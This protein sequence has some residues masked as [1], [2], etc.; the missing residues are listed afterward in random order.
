M[1]LSKLKPSERKIEI[2]NPGT[3]EPIGLRVD[4]VH[5]DDERLKKLK[6]SIQDSRVRL[7]SKG[8]FFKAEDIENNTDEL[9][10]TAMTAWEWYNPTGVQGD[11]GFDA[12][13]QPKWNGEVNPAFSRKT[14]MEMFTALPWFRDQLLKEMGDEEAFFSN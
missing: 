9:V 13:K 5:V 3:K 14:V 1:E 12:E 6:R 2:L 11:K 10:F 4:I 7:E 8:K